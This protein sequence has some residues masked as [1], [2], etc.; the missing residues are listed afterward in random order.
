MINLGDEV[1]DTVSGFKGIVVSRTEFLHGCYRIGV[2]P[3][4]KK[5]GKLEESRGFDEP[6]LKLVK[7]KK[8][9]QGLKNTG[10]PAPYPISQHEHIER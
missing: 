9:K 1:I 5:D 7:P 10:G 3:K 4:M 8:V 2:Q 6:Q